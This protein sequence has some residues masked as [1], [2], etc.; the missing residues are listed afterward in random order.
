LQYIP[1]H[2]V[3]GP[4]GGSRVVID[5]AHHWWQAGTTASLTAPPTFFVAQTDRYASRQGVSLYATATGRL[6]RYLTPAQPGGGTSS[7]LL[8]PAGKTVVYVVYV[9]GA[10]SCASDIYRVAIDDRAAPKLLVRGGSGPVLESAIA[11]AGDEIVYVQGHCNS[12]G[13]VLVARRLTGS[14]RAVVLYRA[15]HGKGVHMV[16]WGR[17]GW[18]SFLTTT[19]PYSRLHT[20]TATPAGRTYSSPSAPTGCFWSGTAWFVERGQDRL[21]ASLQCGAG[22]RWLVLNGD[23]GIVRTLAAFGNQLGAQAIS[24]DA[25]GTW[26]I[27]QENGVSIAGTIWRW[28]FASSSRPQR[29]TQ[30]PY[31][32]S[33][34]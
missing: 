15:T 18:L 33:W 7:P 34:R 12:A 24:V 3:T 1:D 29:V 20:M 28:R 11:P 4:H 21:L 8:D 25:T 5:V 16:R 2:P 17:N 14:A 30:G 19:G 32:P 10:G 6:V 23:L 22:S 27:Y 9:V 13:A 31:S 26:V